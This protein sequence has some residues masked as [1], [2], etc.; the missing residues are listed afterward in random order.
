MHTAL[1]E[2]VGHAS[3]QLNP[4]VKTPKETLKN[5]SS[6]LEEARADL[7]GLYYILDQKM[8]DLG[9]VGCRKG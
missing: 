1:H 2:V 9:L 5:Y 8:V 7:V 4:G 6:T 3:G